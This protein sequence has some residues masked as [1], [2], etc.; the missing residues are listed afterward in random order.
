MEITRRFFIG[1]CGV[2]GIANPSKA[3]PPPVPVAK[4]PIPRD[5]IAAIWVQ[6]P[7][8]RSTKTIWTKGKFRDPGKAI[9]GTLGA[10]GDWDW[11][12]RKAKIRG[13]Q[14]TIEGTH[15]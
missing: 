14:T 10:Q 9:G 1:L 15:E 3:I 4:V 13:D 2:L 11:E 8:D 7:L 12:G 5:Q 6:N